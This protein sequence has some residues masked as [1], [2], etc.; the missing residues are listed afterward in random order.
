MP[1][2]ATQPDILTPETVLKTVFGYDSFRGQQKEVIDH[3]MNGGSCCTLMPTG[4]GKSLCYQ[5]P[6]LCRNGVG[7]IVS[8]LIAL[9]QDQVSAL[10]EL[11]VRAATLNSS[12]DYQ[13]MQ[14]TLRA[15]ESNQLD[16]IYVAPERLVTD[17]VLQL[18]DNIDIALF[19]IDEAHC[20]SQ[21]GHDFRPEYRMLSNLRERYPHVPCIA[22]TATADEPTR[23][24]ILNQLHL[25]KLFLAGFDRPNI[26]YDVTVKD[27][28]KKQLLEFLKTQAKGESGIIYCLSRKKVDETAAWLADQGYTALPYHAGLDNRIRSANQ[29]CFLKDEGIIIVAT[30]AFGMGINKPDVRFVAHL[31]L[32]SNI[33]AY[34]Q[35]TGRAGRDGLP[36]VAWMLYGLQDVAMRRQMIAGSD[37]PDEQ[38]R[39]EHHK[40]GALLGYCEAAHCRRQVLLQYF[41]D[42]HTACGNCD[43][44]NTPP[45][46]V[47]GLIPA[48]K[49]LSCIHRTGNMF[50][51]KHIV[52]VLTATPTPQTE[53]HRHDQVSTWG[54]GTDFD[55]KAW[56]SFIR[57]MVAANL[58][59]VDMEGHGGLKI[60][61]DG[62]AFLK[63][64]PALNLR[65]PPKRTGHR[66]RASAGASGT[67]EILETESDKT[68]YAE[69]KALRLSIAKTNNLPPYVIFHDKTLLAMAKRRPL[70]RD[71]FAQIPGVGQSKLDKYADAFLNVIAE[72]S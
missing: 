42:D 68:L 39:V 21:W 9:M 1:S 55:R 59:F 18:L 48:Q 23:K 28:S 35:E 22:V 19:A 49:I 66:D 38:K 70:Q 54:I 5:I 25:D 31:D 11:G 47:D 3:I 26:R 2:L 46:T 63:E 58:V 44:C 33:E 62:A 16:L 64:K 53:K 71:S 12:L 69:L 34:Y 50:G 36:A 17:Q 41:G 60:T 37:A 4:A 30:I 29:N 65:L 24:D 7:V 67:D 57:Q 27:N 51:A 13:E 20:V 15:L 6:A 14:E 8:P 61:T 43:T 40:L 45:E 32:P 52:D 56:D 10:R 72:A